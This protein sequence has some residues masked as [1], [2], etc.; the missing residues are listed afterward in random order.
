MQ[1]LHN[2]NCTNAH[3]TLHS[4]VLCYELE[5]EYIENIYTLQCRVIF[6]LL[7]WYLESWV[8]RTRVKYISKYARIRNMYL[9]IFQQKQISKYIAQEWMIY[10]YC[11]AVLAPAVTES[12]VGLPVANTAEC[13]LQSTVLCYYKLH[14]A[15]HC[16]CIYVYMYMY[17]RAAVTESWV[18]LVVAQEPVD[19]QTEDRPKPRLATFAKDPSCVNLRSRS[20]SIF[21]SII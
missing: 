8:G 1:I 4:T 14:T 7:P 18:G 15:I 6:V 11:R 21:V 20:S 3:C 5:L 9:K 19:L 2:A 10:M 12:W 16:I 17:C 13:T